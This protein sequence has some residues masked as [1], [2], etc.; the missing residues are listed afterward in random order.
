MALTSTG[1]LTSAGIRKKA[2]DKI[3]AGATR[4]LTSGQ[5]K[6]PL[7]SITDKKHDIRCGRKNHHYAAEE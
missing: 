4:I 5:A 2:C 1:H 3:A 7:R 6:M